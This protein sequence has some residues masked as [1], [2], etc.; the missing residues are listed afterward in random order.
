MRA[1][2][3]VVTRSSRSN[4][5]ATGTAAVQFIRWLQEMAVRRSATTQYRQRRL[6]EG[7]VLVSAVLP[8]PPQVCRTLVLHRRQRTTHSR[9]SVPQWCRDR[10]DSLWWISTV[11]R[12]QWLS[13]CPCSAALDSLLTTASTDTVQRL[14]MASVL[15]TPCPEKKSTVFYV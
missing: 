12:L 2:N 11:V 7:S 4:R 6:H 9:P 1:P 10:P 13:P 14:V 8:D 3:I 15:R 5:N